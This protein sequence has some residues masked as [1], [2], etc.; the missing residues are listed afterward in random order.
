[1]KHLPPSGRGEEEWGDNETKQVTV[2]KET[3]QISSSL[4]SFVVLVT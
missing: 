4:G 1:M 2:P 3:P